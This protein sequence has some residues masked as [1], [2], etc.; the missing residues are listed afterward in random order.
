VKG[1][2]DMRSGQSNRSKNTNKILAA[3]NGMHKTSKILIK[4][5]LFVFLALFVT[6]S[7][8]VILNNTVLPYDPHF[9][10]VSKELVKTSFILAAEAIIGGVV[11]DYVFSHHRS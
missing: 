9:D 8:L 5:G 6:G 1:G 10:M 3:F 11:M 7:V 4:S 2:L